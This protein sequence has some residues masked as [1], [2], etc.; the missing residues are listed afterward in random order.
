MFGENKNKILL[1]SEFT[2]GL[3]AAGS[4]RDR[5]VLSSNYCIKGVIHF[6]I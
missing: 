3:L 2:G 1:G 5:R 4:Q 6:N